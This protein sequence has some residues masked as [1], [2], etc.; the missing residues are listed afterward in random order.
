M[1]LIIDQLKVILLFANFL[2]NYY[3]NKKITQ[4]LEFYLRKKKFQNNN[5]KTIK[6]IL[7]KKII[8][9]K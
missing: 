2:I 1:R 4:D 3:N 5:Y 6:L 8:C 9:K 7:K